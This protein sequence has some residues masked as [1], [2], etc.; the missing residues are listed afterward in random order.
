[1]IVQN[2]KLML[3]QLWWLVIDYG[4]VYE[5]RYMTSNYQYHAM[6]NIQEL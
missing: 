4:M 2:Y 1:M 6:L 5:R 3:V